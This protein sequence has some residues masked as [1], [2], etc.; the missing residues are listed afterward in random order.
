[1]KY[2][3]FSI[4]MLLA[5]CQEQQKLGVPAKVI[6]TPGITAIY[7]I[8]K[9]N[10]TTNWVLNKQNFNIPIVGGRISALD[11]NIMTGDAEL[12]VLG[13]TVALPNKESA[14]TAETMLKDTVYFD[15]QLSSVGR[16]IIT[17]IERITTNPSAT[18]LVTGDLTL[19]NKSKSIELPVQLQMNE[20][21]IILK[22]LPVAIAPLEWA[23][24][25]KEKKVTCSFSLCIKAKKATN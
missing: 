19:K 6:T 1:M 22:S 3:Y 25:P 2:I 23:I 5:A 12:D 4:F 21:E 7:Q 9:E 13:L 8:D 14:L 20:Q 18:H 11:G 10:S 15:T 24:L 16:F 17:K